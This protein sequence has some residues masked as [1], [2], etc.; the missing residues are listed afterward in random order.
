MYHEINRE[1]METLGWYAHCVP[2]GDNTPYGY[3]Y[4]T[5]G[6]EHSFKHPNIQIVLPIDFVA[7]HNIAYAI[8]EKIRKGVRFEANIDYKG[9]MENDY[10]IRFIDAK[11]CGRSVLRLLIP[12]KN[13]KY[14]GEFAAQLTMLD[15]NDGLPD[16]EKIY[17]QID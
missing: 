9:I 1:S 13:G 6:M 10:L 11:E 7:A 12:D 17:H 4:H 8:V 14:E 2:S 16:D 5:H 15:S 3:N